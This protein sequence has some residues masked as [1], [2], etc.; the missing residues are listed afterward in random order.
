M[1]LLFTIFFF[2]SIFFNT[3]SAEKEKIY[4]K[5]GL[6]NLLGR[7]FNK[8]PDIK[9]DGEW[10]FLEKTFLP[11]DSADLI[12]FREKAIRLMV[13]DI[14]NHQ[15]V[16]NF[17]YGTYYLRILFDN[18][19]HDFALMIPTISS[20]CRLYINGREYFRQGL[21]DVCP[22]KS[23]PAYNPDAFIIKN[24]VAISTTQNQSYLDL[25]IHVS[26][27][28]HADSGLWESITFGSSESVMRKWKSLIFTTGLINGILLLTFFVFLL[29]SFL[30]WD[31]GM[32]LF[33]SLY[34]LTLLIFNITINI[35]PIYY[36]LPDLNFEIQNRIGYLMGFSLQALT[37]LWFIHYTFPNE[38][39]RWLTQLISIPFV[40]VGIYII[41]FPLSLTSSHK[42]IFSIIM[43]IGMIFIAFYILPK[44]AI[45]K[46]KAAIWIL[47]AAYIQFIAAINDLLMSMEIIHTFY[48]STY[49]SLAHVMIQFFGISLILTGTYKKNTE[50]R[51]ELAG[52]NSNLEKIIKERTATLRNQKEILT[53]QAG[54]LANALIELKKMNEFKDNM[55]SLLVHDMKNSLN[56]ITNLA[57]TELVKQAGND[58]LDLVLNILEVQKMEET[59]LKLNCQ[60]IRF[61]DLIEKAIVWIRFG[62]D[63]KNIEV[64]TD[65]E[66]ELVYGDPY[67]LDRVFKNIL[68]NA[69]HYTQR[70]GKIS[71]SLKTNNKSGKIVCSIKNTGSY[72]PVEAR[73]VIF[74]KFT[75]LSPEKDITLASSGLGLYFCGLVIRGHNNEIG[76]DSIKN[77]GTTFWFSMDRAKKKALQKE[78]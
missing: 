64:E 55:T 57:E 56:V 46:R 2:F 47:L 33:F 32:S 50:L 21:P 63:S 30:K 19:D 48:I 76:V 28:H 65:I 26:N 43:S 49:G 14:W 12:R 25:V 29:F 58:I 10:L 73:S 52:L 60:N 6:I 23:I 62:T 3:V 24:N 36:Y 37:Y 66:D 20:S 7:D 67:L 78:I 9:L 74:E 45:N 31:K 59:K 72:I 22:E 53:K 61:L 13:P 41:S 38:L 44:A 4:A 71:I 1:K 35:K 11:P 18:K 77:Q 42:M 54:E 68:S 27:F 39:K 5:D 17:S 40:I 69:V 75:Y 34:V 15:G 70:N 16:P 51:I 8:S